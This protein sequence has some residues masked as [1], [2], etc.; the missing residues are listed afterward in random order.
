MT[1][2]IAPYAKT[3]QIGRHRLLPL[4]GD[5]SSFRIVG[6]Y[7]NFYLVAENQKRMPS[8]Y[9]ESDFSGFYEGIKNTPDE[10]LLC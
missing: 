3:E 6:K 9:I 1:F 7:W 4:Q 2:P 5:L 8:A 10:Q